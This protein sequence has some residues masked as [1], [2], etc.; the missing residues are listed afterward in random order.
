MRFYPIFLDL[1]GR[2]AV[3]VGGGNVAER[4]VQKLLRA[5][6]SVRVISPKL[7]SGLRRLVV[8]NRIH[9]THRKYRKGDLRRAGGRRLTPILVF[10]ATDDVS[11]QRVIREEAGTTAALVNDAG[12][13]AQCDF[14]V[15]ASFTRGELHVAI[16]T[17]GTDPSLARLLRQRLAAASRN[18]KR[19]KGKVKGQKLKVES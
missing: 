7:T 18:I 19:K 17:S 9:V 2:R 1:R 16:S 4:K 11:A 6:A 3:V 8:A 10:A 13:P 12:D 5:G 14:I 15:P